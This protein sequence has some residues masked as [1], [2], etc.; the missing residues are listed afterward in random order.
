MGFAMIVTPLF[1]IIF[2]VVVIVMIAMFRPGLSEPG[3]GGQ[4]YCESCGCA[5]PHFA[6]YCR[7]CGTKL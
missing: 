7:R 2:V 3:Q 6:R 1:L 4:R 5:H